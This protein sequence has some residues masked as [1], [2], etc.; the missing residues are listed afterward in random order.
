MKDESVAIVV[1]LMKEQVGWMAMA[2]Q[3]PVVGFAD[4]FG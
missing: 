1:N 2:N 3:L 4:P